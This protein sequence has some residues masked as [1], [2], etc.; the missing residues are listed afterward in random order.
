MIVVKFPRSMHHGAVLLDLFLRQRWSTFDKTIGCHR[1]DV[2]CAIG[3]PD[4][5][6]G[7]GNLH[8][9]F[10]EVAGRVKHVLMGRS[11]VTAGGVVISTKMSSH[12]T[13]VSGRQQQ[14]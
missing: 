3:K 14:R 2:G 12:T 7:K 4:S 6:T 1:H 10:S 8:H 5:G 11:D 13:S 9:V